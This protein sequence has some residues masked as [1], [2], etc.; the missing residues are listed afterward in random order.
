[1]SVLKTRITSYGQSNSDLSIVGI[2]PGTPMMRPVVR[3]S[4]R[5]DVLLYEQLQP[6]I[7]ADGAPI[8]ASSPGT[9][10]QLYAAGSMR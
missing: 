2:P 3:V 1:M 4:I 9:W 10:G 5:P 7:T 8:V 6:L